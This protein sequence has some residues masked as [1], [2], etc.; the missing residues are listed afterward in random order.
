MKITIDEIRMMTVSCLKV[1]LEET[2][3]EDARYDERPEYIYHSVIDRGG[4]GTEEVIR[5]V[6]RNGLVPRNNGEVGGV[7][8]FNPHCN[9]YMG[10]GR[11]TVRLKMTPENIRDFEITGDGGTFFAHRT[12]PFGRLEVV[13]CPVVVLGDTFCNVSMMKGDVV[14]KSVER[15]GYDSI[16]QFLCEGSSSKPTKVYADVWDRFVEPTSETF[17][18]YPDIEVTNLFK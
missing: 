3:N 6:V 14:R 15:H 1:L 8:W 7:I 2:V 4:I 18:N 11:L 10:N 16:A 12:I 13:D 5:S 9:E 17:R